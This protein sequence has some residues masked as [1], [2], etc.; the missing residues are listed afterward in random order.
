MFAK[1]MQRVLLDGGEKSRIPSGHAA[2]DRRRDPKWNRFD[3]PFTNVLS[4]GVFRPFL[5][6][7]LLNFLCDHCLAPRI[8]NV[9]SRLPAKPGRSTR[10]KPEFL[11]VR[12][13]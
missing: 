10:S 12:L 6:I 8:A 9:D 13:S 1:D 7:E 2:G 3:C 5:P 11:S 4:G